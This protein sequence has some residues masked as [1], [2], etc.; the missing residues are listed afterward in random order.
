M[1]TETD[2]R[3]RTAPP[4]IGW[5]PGTIDQLKSAPKVPQE[6]SDTVAALHASQQAF[7]NPG[8]SNGAAKSVGSG[9]SWAQIA[10]QA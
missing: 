3:L 9:D 8:A 6:A 10:G 7:V 1:T 5:V 2:P 4:Y